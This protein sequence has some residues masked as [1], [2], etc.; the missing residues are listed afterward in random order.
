MPD[1]STNY[2]AARHDA[3]R[4]TDQHSFEDVANVV[5]ATYELYVR[6]ANFV[7]PWNAKQVGSN[8]PYQA[9]ER[10]QLTAAVR[11][12]RAC[13]ADLTH[14]SFIDSVISFCHQ[15]KGRRQLIAPSPA[16]HHSAQ[17]V[18]GTFTARPTF[19]KILLHY[20]RGVR[21]SAP[22]R[23]LAEIKLLG[24]SAPIYV[25]NPTIKLTEVKHLII[26]PRM[27]KLGTTNLSR[28]EVLFFKRNSGYLIEHVDSQINPK[29]CG[30][31]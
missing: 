9:P 29:F 27:G 8:F 31:F 24:I 20:P 14:W 4:P 22:L 3:L 12:P 7:G 23:A 1:E 15:A 11:R 25:E 28:W 17:F 16:T 6:A 26:R 18:S 5:A 2:W 10:E 30:I 19:D 21:P 13:I